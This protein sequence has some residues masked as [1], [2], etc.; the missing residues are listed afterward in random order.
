MSAETR[1]QG[2]SYWRNLFL[3]AIGVFLIGG[4]AVVYVLLPVSY[5]NSVAHPARAS[6]CCRTPA[7][8]G[9]EYNDVR[10]VTADGITLHGMSYNDHSQNRLC[11]IRIH[12]HPL[13]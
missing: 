10:F 5:A 11:L 1:E 12:P 9:L 6:V 8:I 13:P 3:F 4:I 2:L 7:D